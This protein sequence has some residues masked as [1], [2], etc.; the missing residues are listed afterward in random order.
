MRRF[1]S[2]QHL[3]VASVVELNINNEIVKSG[4]EIIVKGHAVHLLQRTHV[5]AAVVELKVH[6]H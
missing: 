6:A 4:F 1:L 2:I 5:V 3:T